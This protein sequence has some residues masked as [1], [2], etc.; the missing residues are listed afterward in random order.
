MLNAARVSCMFIRVCSHWC[1]TSR[2]DWF[3]LINAIHYNKKMYFAETL[4]SMNFLHIIEIHI[5]LNYFE[6]HFCVG[7][8]CQLT[9]STITKYC[10]MVH[11]HLNCL[12]IYN[13]FDFL[14]QIN[15]CIDIYNNCAILHYHGI[16][17]FDCVTFFFGFGLPWIFCNYSWI[18]LN[19]FLWFFSAWAWGF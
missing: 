9:I 18:Y 12:A 10:L 6:W 4:S 11:I 2:N 1:K 15:V 14:C 8:L 19:I 3:K 7:F 5:Y 13:F 16:S 17:D